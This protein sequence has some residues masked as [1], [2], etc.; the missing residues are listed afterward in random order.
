MPIRVR[1]TDD[2]VDGA[3]DGT[4]TGVGGCILYAFTII[5]SFDFVLKCFFFKNIL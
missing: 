2:H 5:D 1:H 4:C 3:S